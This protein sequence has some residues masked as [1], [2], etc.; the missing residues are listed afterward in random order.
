MAT[1]DKFID[2]FG[3][4][5][6]A[7]DMSKFNVGAQPPGA[8]FGRNVEGQLDAIQESL[9]RRDSFREEQNREAARGGDVRR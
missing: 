2:T 4:T 6:T 3:P 9:D 8:E 1:T 7:P 5:D